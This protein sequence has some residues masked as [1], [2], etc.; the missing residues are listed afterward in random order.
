MDVKRGEIERNDENAEEILME[1]IGNFNGLTDLRKL[2]S[3]FY[4]S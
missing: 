3:A 2:S 4:C 1:N